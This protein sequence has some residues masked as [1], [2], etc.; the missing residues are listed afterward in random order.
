MKTALRRVDNNIEFDNISYASMDYGNIIHNLPLGVLSPG[1]VDDIAQTVQLVSMI[2]PFTGLTMAAGGKRHS[3]SGQAQ[4]DNGIFIDMPSNRLYETVVNAGA[5]PPY[6]DVY[7][8]DM[9]I[10]VLNETLKYGLAPRSWTD[11]LHITVGGTLSNAGISGQAFRYGPQISNVLQLEVVTGTGEIVNCSSTENDDLFFAVLGGLGQFGIITRARII[12]EP[13]PQKVKR[14]QALYSNFTVF[15][16]D[17]ELLISLEK[18]FDYIEG[19]VVKNAPGDAPLFRLEVN[20]NFNDSDDPKKVQAEIDGLLAKLSYNTSTLT[21]TESTYVEFL[22]RVY[23]AEL[24]LRSIGLWVGGQITHPWQNLLMPKSKIQTF[25]SEVFYNILRDTS[26]GPVIV[27]PLNKSKWDNRTS[28][29]L[30]E[31]DIFYAVSL[32]PRANI[33]SNGT[34]GL[35]YMLN[36]RKRIS[37]FCESAGIGANQYL[38]YHETPE[39]WQNKHYGAERWKVLTQRKQTYDP[40]CIL[41]PGQNI[42]TA[43]TCPGSI[44]GFK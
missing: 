9:W 33:S 25:A 10:T 27:Y 6:A 26:L 39:E 34:D 14:I 20:K 5:N 44:G 31:G 42:F 30:P 37:D 4:T 36:Q 8:G 29:V 22:E 35:E 12:L 1:S 16:G 11:Y 41:A 3:N 28:V 23:T 18:T 43:D 13:A 17:Q 19:M 21:I 32:L 15:S 24:F 7:A 40:S 38:P 2:G